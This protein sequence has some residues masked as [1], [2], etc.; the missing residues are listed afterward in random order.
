MEQRQDA[1]EC[2]ARHDELRDAT[3][4]TKASNEDDGRSVTIKHRSSV[5]ELKNGKENVVN[6]VQSKLNL[7]ENQLEHFKAENKEQTKRETSNENELL[8]KQREIEELRISLAKKDTQAERYRHDIEELKKRGKSDDGQKLLKLPSLA[9]GVYPSLKRGI[10]K[11][12][13]GRA[14]KPSEC[15]RVEK[16]CTVKDRQI[17]QLEKR[18]QILEDNEERKSKDLT[19]LRGKYAEKQRENEKLAEELKEKRGEIKKM[20]KKARKYDRLEKQCSEKDRQRQEQERLIEGLTDEKLK[21]SKDL[22]EMINNYNEKESENVRLRKNIMQVKNDLRRKTSQCERLERDCSEKD[23]LIKEK[24]ILIQILADEKEE[25][26]NGLRRKTSQYEKLVKDCSEKD[27]LIKE[28]ER[29]IQILADEKEEVN[30]GLRRKTS[31]YEK[32]VK[33]CSEKDHLIKEKERMIQILAD[34]KEEVNNGLRR[35]TS[36]YEKLVKDCSEKDHLIKEKERMIQILADEKE[37]VNNGLRRE[38][39]QCERLVKDCSEKDHLIKEQERLI[40]ILADE[41]EEIG[42]DL[43]K[44]KVKYNRKGD[45]GNE[46][47]SKAIRGGIFAYMDNRIGDAVT[48]FDEALSTGT[49]SEMEAA[50]LYVFRATA[51][52][53]AEKPDNLAII[54]DC[55]M[56]IEKGLKGWKVYQLRGQHLMD[57]GLY[58]IAVQDFEMVNRL[59]PS[60][61][62]RRNLNIAKEKLAK[63][64]KLSHYEVLGVKQTDTKADI[65][66]AFRNLSMLYHP[67]RHRDKPE[68]LQEAFQEKFKR[69]TEAKTVLTDEVKRRSY[70]R[71]H[72]QKMNNVDP[73]SKARQQRQRHPQFHRQQQ[74]HQFHHQQNQHQS[75]RTRQPHQF[76]RQQHYWFSSFDFDDIMN[77]F[78]R[79]W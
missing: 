27:H 12:R 28:K 30:N 62:T 18:I 14:E 76:Q 39:C 74:P 52:S 4:S 47:K 65:L 38:T 24:E 3:T 51:K 56:A 42:K 5:S 10:R 17:Q 49:S 45:E 2:G 69:I 9:K 66:R 8:S 46:G 67:D 48:I 64:V 61:E 54:M 37:E 63:W 58:S 21:L 71:N 19:E 11:F 15:E 20:R 6:G 68:I 31:Q 34:E 73:M 72:R 25:V 50:L 22:Q 16:D 23:H 78:F 55:C 1:E 33:D 35:K 70:D 75:H 43:E 57:E 40:Q 26:N 79:F 32:L 36:Q 7:L 13:G 29:L 60:E 77:G 53:A 41:K 59:L 44:M